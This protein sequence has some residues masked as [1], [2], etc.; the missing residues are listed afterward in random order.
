MKIAIVPGS[1]DPVTYG[2]LSLIKRAAAMFDKVIVCCMINAEKKYLFSLP[3]RL[4]LL[5]KVTEDIPGVET[6][7]WEGM[8]WEYAEKTGA[9]AIVKGVRNCRDLEYETEMADFNREH[10]P[11]AETVILLPLPGLEEVS[12]TAARNGAQQ[13]KE[14]YGLV[15]PVV[16]EALDKKYLT[17]N[18]QE[19]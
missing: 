3:E 12:S 7:S 1:F 8:L 14:I 13:D 19:E 4:E 10:C 6:D 5:G 2:H 16:A 15:P 11:A 18:I 9:C 17:D